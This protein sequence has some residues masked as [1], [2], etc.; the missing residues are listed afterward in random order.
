MAALAEANRL[1]RVGHGQTFCCLERRHCERPPAVRASVIDVRQ[2]AAVQSNRINAGDWP[3]PA[4][5]ICVEY[6]T[7]D[8]G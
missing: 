8:P 2:S 3:S 4:V 1:L 6:R 5:A 7:F